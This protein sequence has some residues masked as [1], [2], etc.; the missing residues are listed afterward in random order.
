MVLTDRRML[1]LR[2]ALWTARPKTI[3]AEIP[4]SEVQGAAIAADRPD[5]VSVSI[6]RGGRSK[7]GATVYLR[8]GGTVTV[9]VHSDI[10]EGEYRFFWGELTVFVNY[11]NYQLGSIDRSKP[12]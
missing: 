10:S 9:Q 6:Y 2:R 1:V 12:D 8:D 4:L 7:G 11:L 3:L 5:S